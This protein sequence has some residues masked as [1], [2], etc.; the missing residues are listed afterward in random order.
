MEAATSTNG[1]PRIEVV[2]EPHT[3]QGHVERTR[4]GGIRVR[5]YGSSYY[6]DLYRLERHGDQGALARLERHGR[7]VEVELE[8][9]GLVLPEGVEFDRPP[10]RRAPT[11]SY[12][13]PPL[14][15]I[16]YFATA[17][18]PGRVLADLA[19]NFDLPEGVF[20]VNLPRETQATSEGVEPLA[21][22]V[23]DVDS[24]DAAVTSPV[25]TIAGEWDVPLQ[26]LDQSPLSAPFDWVAFT[27]LQAD[28]DAQL[29]LQL[30]NGSGT[31]NSIT[32]ILN[33]T[34]IPAA[35]IISYTG[36][37]EGT[38]TGATAM[39]ASLGLAIAKIGQNRSAPPEVWLMTTSRMAWLGSS[40]DTQNRP[41]MIADRDG[42]GVFD[43]IAIPV[44]LDD[45][46]PRT[47]NGN[48]EP[49][50][51][52][53]PSDWLVLESEA[54]SRVM[55]E[56]VSGS[57]MVRLQYY[58]YAAGLLRYPSSVAYLTGSGMATGG[59]F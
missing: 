14:W 46:I 18:R 35:N 1:G 11:A 57:L 20:S 27:Q 40:E 16:D 24:A 34:A 44:E 23:I 36:A 58:R 25:T 21:A 50:F 33:N 13:A 26:M 38:T 15:L 55:M 6:Q 52:C 39:F 3:Y 32:G 59:G 5:S 19:P 22:G 41:L 17:P 12:A 8:R 7:E 49:V 31:G 4:R 29:E 53:R 28:Y 47:L 42:S 2:S 48:Q 9:R 45:A 37:G 56:P 30:I 51:A 54:K 10:E 43:L